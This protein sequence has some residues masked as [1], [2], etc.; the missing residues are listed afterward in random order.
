MTGYIVLGP[1]YFFGD[2]MQNHTEPGFI[3]RRTAWLAHRLKE[4]QAAM[5]QWIS[6]V[7]AMYGMATYCILISLL[8]LTNFRTWRALLSCWQ[9]HN[10][11]LTVASA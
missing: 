5:P 11:I 6:D 9:V 1:D 7:T 8:T 3:E 4:A 10:I 2:Y